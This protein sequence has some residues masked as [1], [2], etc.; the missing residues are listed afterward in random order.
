MVNMKLFKF[1]IFLFVTQ[2]ISA[3]TTTQNYVVTTIP[4][5]SVS[6]PASL[7]DVNSN[8]IIQYIDGRGRLSQTVQKAI[9]PNSAD[10]ISVS[11]YSVL[12]RDSLQWLPAVVAS[13]NGAYYSNYTNYCNQSIS[14]NAGD[15]KPYSRTEYEPSPLNRVTGQYAPGVDWYT[16]SKKV[17]TAY[18]VNGTDVKYFYIESNLLKCNG[19]Y[20]R[21]TLN[22]I[23]TTDEDGKTIV[24]YT[25]KIGRKVLKRVAGVY[26]TYYVFDDIGNLRY[27]LPPL[28]ADA[29]N[30]NTSGFSESAGSVLDLFAYIY[31]YDG[32]KRLVEKKLPGTSWAYMVYDKADRLILSSDGNQYNKNNHQWTVAK[33]DKF[34]RLLY[35]GLIRINSSRSSLE[36]SN[37][38]S[39]YNDSYTGAVSTGGYSSLILPPSRLLT[40]NYYD[41]YTYRTGLSTYSSISATLGSTTQSGYPTPD[42]THNKSLTTGVCNYHLD[43][44][45]KFELTAIYYDKYGRVVQNRSSN[46]LAG[47][48][49]T[50]NLVD[51]IGKPTKTYK[52]HGISGASTTITEEYSYTFDKAQR[53][54]TTTHKLNGGTT[55]TLSTNT[56]DELGR[57]SGKTVGGS[58]VSTAYTYNVRSWLTGLTNPKFEENLYYYYNQASLPSFVSCYNGN[59]S[60]MKWT[61]TDDNLGYYRAYSFN[62]DDLNRLTSG[63]YCGKS[64]ITTVSGTTGKFDENVTYD[65]MGNISTL[66]RKEDGNG[67]NYLTYTYSGNQLTKVDNSLSPTIPYGSE[68]FVDR[69]KITTEYIYDK[70][71]NTVYDANRGISTIRFNLL[72]LPE[73]VQFT[74]GHQNW[75]VYSAGGSKLSATSYTLNTAITVPQGTITPVPPN[76]ADYV[77]VVN[78]YIGNIIYQNSSLKQIQTSEGY[79]QGG[80]YYYYL[81]DHLGNTRYVINS[82]GTKIETSHYYPFGMRFFIGST[83]NSAAIGFRYNGKEFDAMNGLYSYD[84]GARF[85]DPQ[86]G[87]WHVIDGKAENMANISPYTYCINN[88][89]KLIDPDG[90][91][92]L[93]MHYSMV[94]SVLTSQKLSPD[95]IRAITYGASTRAD[96]FNASNSSVHLDNMSGYKSI[97]TAYNNAKDGFRKEMNNENFENAGESLHTVADFYSHSNYLELYQNYAKEN[98]ISLDIN[99]I[100]TFSEA[101]NDSKLKSFLEENGLKTGTY[102]EG[103]MMG[104]KLSKDPNA[105]GNMNLDSNK[106]PAGKKIFTGK[107]TMHEAAKAV[108]QKELENT[109]NQ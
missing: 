84:Y 107:T 32:R 102:G 108:A 57:T 74:A 14:S 76:P 88:P 33:Y 1:L 40:V 81:K 52:T 37:S 87:R 65:K 39:V 105:H 16:N 19:T 21:A 23:Q 12:G 45:T 63:T 85:Y 17:S 53:L 83:T 31:H 71:G 70:N 20:S 36:G 24:E 30:T 2:V 95:A 41:T 106:S 64:G 56:Y 6:D 26:D 15:T 44:S 78:D 60:G 79:C 10:L 27:I 100:P 72:N 93:T 47:Y 22:G 59:I 103:G 104:D 90:K 86:I 77:K 46:H 75:Y 48:D 28:A 68:A 101:M 109:V 29:L 42:L 51:F 55:V 7:T 5:Q 35:T 62:Y 98:E 61:I 8:T 82:S 9:T 94:Q 58:L 80:I 69:A 18:T 92:P 13:N 73:V 25:D 49:L 89:V 34:G 66:N 91:F 11:V 96:I 50:Y 54:L 99:K 67:L 43:D 4:F 38:S 3:Q 97:S